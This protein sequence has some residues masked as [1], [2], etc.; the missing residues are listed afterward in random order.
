MSRPR[1]GRGAHPQAIRRRRSAKQGSAHPSAKVFPINQSGAAD[2]DVRPE[3]QTGDDHRHLLQLGP[4]ELRQQRR[5]V[6]HGRRAV[7]G[8]FDTRIWDKTHD[9]KKA[10]GWTV[11]VLDN[12]GNGKRDAYTEPEPAGGSDQG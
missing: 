8:W 2:A 9:E 1:L 3:D 6:V 4:S 12:N 10:Q 5:A 7:E 11:F